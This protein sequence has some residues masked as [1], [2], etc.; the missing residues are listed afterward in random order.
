[1]FLTAS[2]DIRARRRS[3][4]LAADPGATAAVTRHEQHRRDRADA[5]QTVM[6][7]DAVE[8]DSTTLSLDEVV[9]VIVG[10]VRDR[11][12]LAEHSP[13]PDAVWTG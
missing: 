11:G 13:S 10:L 7:A 1:M 12:G 3:A 4:D 9:G 5:P 2:E 6:A 8:I